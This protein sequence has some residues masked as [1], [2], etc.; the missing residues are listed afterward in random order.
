MILVLLALLSGCGGARVDC[1]DPTRVA[2]KAGEE[3]LVCSEA[4]QVADY[5]HL[6][7][8]RALTREQR[9]RVVQG[10]AGW[11]EKDPV[12]ARK[13]LDEIETSGR[14]IEGLTG[15]QGAERRGEL[16]WQAIRGE[17]L[18]RPEHD[19]IW[20]VQQTALAVWAQDDDER[21][22]LTEMDIEGWLHYASLCREVQGGGPLR[23]SVAD[24]VQVYRM[25]Q[26]AFESGSREEQIAL[27]AI[28]PYWSQI[29][30]GWQMASYE[31]QQS[32]IQAA[33]LPPPMTATSLGYT[34]ALLQGDLVKHARVLHERIGPFTMVK[35]RPAFED[36]EL[37]QKAE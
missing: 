2:A 5:L 24:R 33:P 12:A 32:W 28:G 23:L 10:V 6:L 29:R 30:E 7:A 13:W 15:L 22:A 3:Q 35:G 19:A 16:V 31:R 8:G 26:A 17:G 25:I 20:T 4:T 1:S 18:V 27:L 37:L 9:D 34:E 21:L 36:V 14:A 11:F